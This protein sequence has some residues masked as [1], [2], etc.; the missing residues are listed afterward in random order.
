MVTNEGEAL[1]LQERIGMYSEGA[2]G[3]HLSPVGDWAIHMRLDG[4]FWIN[5]TVS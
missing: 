3:Q 5:G 2:V 4:G 1:D